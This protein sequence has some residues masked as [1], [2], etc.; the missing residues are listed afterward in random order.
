MYY[1]EYDPSDPESP[2]VVK[3]D[4]RDGYA[5]TYGRYH[6]IDDAKMAL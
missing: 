3:Y 5:R 2:Y 1:W 6:S 4:H